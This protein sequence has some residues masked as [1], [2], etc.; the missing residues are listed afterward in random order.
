MTSQDSPYYP[1][2]DHGSSP[3]AQA[4]TENPR[5]PFLLADCV[6]TVFSIL[7]SLGFTIYNYSVLQSGAS[8]WLF[9]IAAAIP[10]I[11][12]RVASIHG[13]LRLFAG[14]HE[15][16]VWTVAASG[17]H[18]IGSLHSILQTSAHFMS[19]NPSGIPW[20]PLVAGGPSLVWNFVFILFLLRYVRR[21]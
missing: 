13:N 14:R 18:M 10:A 17:Y 11:V 6:V 12:A 4:Q 1:G 5:H 3:A 2:D 7:V 21:G 15:G 20:M 8:R 9:I 19:N 16:L